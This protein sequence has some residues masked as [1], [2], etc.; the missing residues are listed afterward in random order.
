M[1]QIT[2]KGF[3]I[4]KDVPQGYWV[5]LDT[6]GRVYHTSYDLAVQ[7]IEHLIKTD[8]NLCTKV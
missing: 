2:Y 3:K 7:F 4:E 5:I 8:N 1:E 6:S